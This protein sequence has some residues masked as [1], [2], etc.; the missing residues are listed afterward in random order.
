M[1]ITTHHTIKVVIF[2]FAI[3]TYQDLTSLVVTVIVLVAITEEVGISTCCYIAVIVAMVT[4]IFVCCRIVAAEDAEAVIFTFSFI[5]GGT[6]VMTEM[7][8]SC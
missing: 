7:A 6:L 1:A 8:T 5:S 4:L 3:F 2:I